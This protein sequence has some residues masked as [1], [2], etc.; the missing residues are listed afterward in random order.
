MTSPAALKAP[1]PD[2]EQPAALSPFA[3]QRVRYPLKLRLLRVKKVQALTPRFIRITLT[4]DDLE[5]FQSAG[6]DD[7]VKVFFPAPGADKPIMPEAGPNGP[8]FP[9]G[10]PRPVARDITPRRFDAAAGELELEFALHEK[11]PASDWAR[12]AKIGQCLGVGGPK[13]S[14]IIPPAFDWYLLIGDETALPAIGR[15]L[16]ELPASTNALVIVEVDAPEFQIAL[17][18]EARLS[19]TWCHRRGATSHTAPLLDALR[20]LSLPAG[21]GFTWAAGESAV[22]KAIRAYLTGAK[23]IGKDRIRASSYWKPGDES[24][25]ET[26]ED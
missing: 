4:G 21:E 13:G 14:K 16:E 19:V 17:R 26:F 22:I 10:A 24:V 20:Q 25:H 12:Q 8:V 1:S 11:G 18:S 5:G 3:V 15:R 9:E 7:H 6:F 2:N 23:G